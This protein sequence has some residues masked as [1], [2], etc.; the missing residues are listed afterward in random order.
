MPGLQF[1]LFVPDSLI[2]PSFDMFGVITVYIIFISFKSFF[3][4]DT[5]FIRPTLNKIII[6]IVYP[7]LDTNKYNNNCSKSWGLTN[8]L[9]SFLLRLNSRTEAIK[10]QLISSKNAHTNDIK[11]WHIQVVV[12]L[13]LYELNLALLA[14]ATMRFVQ[15]STRSPSNVRRQ[16]QPAS[17]NQMYEFI[18]VFICICLW[19]NVHLDLKLRCTVV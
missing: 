5:V 7:I 6:Y 17:S 10:E 9:H 1:V 19:T 8:G 16:R 3:S 15:R 12:N 14:V 2:L 11:V 18:I 4:F 13:Y